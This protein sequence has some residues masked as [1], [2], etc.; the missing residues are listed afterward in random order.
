MSLIDTITALAQAIGADIK[1]LTANK[2]SVVAGKGLST[3]DYTTAEK[4]KLGTTRASGFDDLVTIAAATG[5]VTL[6]MSLATSFELTLTGNTTIAFSNMPVPS[7]Q[8]FSFVVRITQGATLRTVTWPG[9]VTWLTVGAVKVADPAV[10]K[11]VEYVFSTKNGTVIEG[12]K[13]RYT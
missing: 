12:G 13:G 7:G 6:N 3:N 11:M 5:T 2:V 8:V 4:T 9:S 10:N 1:S